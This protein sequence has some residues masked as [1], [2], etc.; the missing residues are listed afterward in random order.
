MPCCS[1]HFL[2]ASLLLLVWQ[3]PARGEG[4][5]NSA[6]QDQS[7]A[8]SERQRSSTEAMQSAVEKQR[9]SVRRQVTGHAASTASFFTTPWLD[10]PLVS[11]GVASSPVA[12]CEAL[13]S[14]TLEPLVTESAQR[15]SVSATLIRA[16]IS[17]E[18][19]G[20]PCA[21]SPKGAQGIMQLMPATQIDLG[22]RDPF[23]PAENIAAGTKYIKQLLDR[24]KGDTSLALAAYNAGPNRVIAEGGVPD[25]PETRDYVSGIMDSVLKVMAQQ[26]SE[27]P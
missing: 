25:I 1:S 20:R 10:A 24:F 17:K 3:I 2:T 18:S 26:P 15:E 23:D 5:L 9:N 16:M 21:V 19:G 6:P 8:S 4:P 13:P 14:E 12:D 27:G 22:V 11:A 7:A